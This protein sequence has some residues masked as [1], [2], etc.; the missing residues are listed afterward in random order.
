M[1]DPNVPAPTDGAPLSR[2]RRWTLLVG[3]VVVVLLLDQLTKWWA[4]SQLAPPPEGNGRIVDV[5]AS[6]RF[7]YAENT[8]MAFSR[9][10][11]SGRWIGLLVII[12]VVVMVYFATRVRSPGLVVTLGVVVGGALGNL[13]DRLLRA[14]DG[15]LSGAVVDFIDLQWWPVFN[16]ADAAVVVGGIVL[17]LLATREPEATTGREADR[18]DP[19]APAGGEEGVG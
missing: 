13:L 17:V 12:V 14:E 7:R 8:G 3:S 6:L 2:G 9:G 11:E 5:V 16:V 15:W 4:V 19:A 1:A 10:A 18:Q